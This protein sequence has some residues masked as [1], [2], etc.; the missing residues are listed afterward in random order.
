VALLWADTTL[1]ATLSSPTGTLPLRH[2]TLAA[3]AASHKYLRDETALLRWYYTAPYALFWVCALNELCLVC[4]Y[5]RAHL[6][7]IAAVR[8]ARRWRRA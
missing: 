7:E 2:S 1:G 5:L 3:G 6:G 8:W 4:L